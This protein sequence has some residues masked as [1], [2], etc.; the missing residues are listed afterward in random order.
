[1]KDKIISYLSQLIYEHDVNN[2]CTSYE[3]AEESIE[4][5]I[6]K[7]FD[8]FYDVGRYDTLHEVLSIIQ[9]LEG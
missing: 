7:A 9:K 4:A 3:K 1:M 6:N 5:D 8:K 2:F